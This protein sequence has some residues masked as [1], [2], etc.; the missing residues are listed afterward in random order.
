MSHFATEVGVLAAKYRIRPFYLAPYHTAA[1]MPLDQ[2]PN[3]EF[4]R[5]WSEIRARQ[6]NFSSLQALDAC[7]ECWDHGYSRKHVLKGWSS[8]GLT[9]DEPVCRDKVILQRGGQLFRKTVPKQDRNYVGEEACKVFSPPRG[10]K[11]AIESVRCSSCRGLVLPSHQ[12]CPTCRKQNEAFSSISQAVEAGARQQGF[13]RKATCLVDMDDALDFEP[14][15]K[16]HLCKVWGD[17]MSKV[18]G[19]DPS[20][21]GTPAPPSGAA[22]STPAPAP[23]TPAMPAS[24]LQVP[25]EEAPAVSEAPQKEGPKEYDLDIGEDVALYILAHF[26]SS[27]QGEARPAVEYFV[28]QMKKKTT[29][30]KPL[31]S[32]IHQEI[33]GTK[34][35]MKPQS[36]QMWL[37]CWQ[38]NRSQ[39]Y[40]SAPK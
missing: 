14:A 33:V 3:K 15:A 6:S 24:S 37:A 11:R 10:Y 2:S 35:L 16:K 40:V 30:A 39:R 21:P 20:A 23:S 17:M 34:V 38:K 22:P 12:Y 18:A 27:A 28:G 19:K 25:C 32:W 1:L 4:E 7:H 36:R 26:K 8:V 29:K 9:P 13:R 5:H 31:S